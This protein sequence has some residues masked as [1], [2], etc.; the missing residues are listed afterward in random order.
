MTDTGTTIDRIAPTK[1]PADSPTGHQIWSN[2]LFI[3]WRVSARDI[4]E[5]LPARLTVDTFDGSAWVG[6][7]PFTMSGVRPWWSPPV[8]G[9]STFHETNVRTYVCHK[10]QGPGAWFFSLDA[11]SSLAVC[12]ARWRWSLPYFRSTM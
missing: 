11:S 6:L 5:L 12:V 2:L 3:H 10:D 1:R 8:P 9:I 7:V 4:V